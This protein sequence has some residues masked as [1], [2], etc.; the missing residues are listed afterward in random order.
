LKID[1]EKLRMD[2]LAEQMKFEE[3]KQSY[4]KEMHDEYEKA[5][6]HK[7]AIIRMEVAEE[8]RNHMSSQSDANNHQLQFQ[9]PP[10]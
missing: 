10:G 5:I 4:F 2:L 7:E 1:A 9:V 6:M 3:A 8:W